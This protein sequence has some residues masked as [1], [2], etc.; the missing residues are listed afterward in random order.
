MKRTV[1]RK[2]IYAI[3]V[4][5][6]AVSAVSLVITAFDFFTLY[7]EAGTL[8]AAGVELYDMLVDAVFAVLEL[9]LG[10]SLIKK[11]R[12]GERIETHKT[13]SQLIGAAVYAPFAK[14]LLDVVLV[15]TMGADG[16]A[17]NVNLAYIIVY[18]FY[19]IVV[20]STPT[21]IKKRQLMNL[22]YNTALTSVLAIGF[23]IYGVLQADGDAV[24]LGMGVANA[25][26]MCLV[27]AF[28]ILSAIYYFKNPDELEQDEQEGEDSEVIR[29]TE[30]HEVVK[31]YQARGT[32]DGINVL[33]RVLTV[34]SACFGIAGI[35]LYMMEKGFVTYFSGSLGDFIALFTNIGAS[36]E[37]VGTIFIAFIYLLIY[38]GV[39]TA[40]FGSDG[41]AKIAVMSVA[42]VGTIFAM[43]TGI[44][45]I[46][47]VIGEFSLTHT[48]Q[49]EKR[50]FF[51]IG[52]LV[53]YIVYALT[54]RI[55]ANMSKEI[56]EGIEKR[57]DAYR[58]HSA[59]IARLVFFS[60]LFSVA[61]FV[62]LFVTG[63]ADGT[64]CL[65]Y[66]SFLLSTVLI[67]I[68]TRLEVNHPFDEFTVV[69]RKRKN[70]EQETAQDEE[71]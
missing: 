29:T 49:L 65:S 4:L 30:T 24:T 6:F 51:E 1:E 3:G 14:V 8:G 19:G 62:L 57:G 61:V 26:I 58:D 27:C 44:F 18:I 42:S 41:Q 59:E 33:I 36:A 50:S 40:I 67:M 55:Y 23:S 2:L 56:S 5:A 17:L 39:A 71:E 12:D 22:C 43:F 53:L 70:A 37:L 31:I 28:G 10:F 46:L 20:M 9:T 45:V 11:W 21:L 32:H 64:L 13:L 7:Q 38:I 66:P 60:G 34:A 69:T 25:L 63:L 52:V 35:V 15:Y 68:S 16:S 48:L 47:D 54:K